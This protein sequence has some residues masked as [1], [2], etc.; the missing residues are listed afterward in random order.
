MNTYSV[1]SGGV[2]PFLYGTAS[3]PHKFDFDFE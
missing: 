2:K 3:A 1:L